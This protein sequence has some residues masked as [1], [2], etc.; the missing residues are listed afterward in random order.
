MDLKLK[1]RLTLVTGSSSG[2]G[3][4]IASAFVA[5]GASVLICG[6]D[7]KKLRTTQEELV[8]LRGGLVNIGI[9]EVTNRNSIEKLFLSSHSL[10]ADY[11]LVKKLDILVNNVG[12]AEKFGSFADLTDEDWERSLNLNFYSMLWFCEMALP[13]LKKSSAPRIVNISS[14]P[15]HQPGF[16]NPHYSAA[17]AAMLNYSKHLA[18]VLAK[19]GIL[20]NTVCPSTIQSGGWERNV[21]DRAQRDGVTASEAEQRMLDEEKKK[22]PLGKIGQ[23][24]DV[25]NI[26]AFLA[27]PLNQFITGQCID[28]DGGITRSIL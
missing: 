8:S 6:R 3:K 1:S 27:S 16:Y 19:D 26:V 22:S 12:G 5:E 14:V 18:N 7:I 9:V 15:A 20:V 25:A 24:E 21:L 10:L 2:L 28:V 4:A 13:F 11:P 23:P 17:K